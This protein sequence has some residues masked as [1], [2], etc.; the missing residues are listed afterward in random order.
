MFC[1]C[2]AKELNYELQ[3]EIHSLQHRVLE[4]KQRV[5]QLK[6]MIQEIKGKIEREERQSEYQD[7]ESITTQSTMSMSTHRHSIATTG[8]YVIAYVCLVIYGLETELKSLS[9]SYETQVHEL[10][11]KVDAIQKD[12]V[13]TK[14][15]LDS[16]YQQQR[17][18]HKVSSVESYVVLFSD[19]KYT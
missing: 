13:K 5:N 12:N 11:H 15:S 17:M 6:I 2:S 10:K 18:A 1:G 16:E 19:V 8:T 14:Q 4:Y 7:N 3:E 9:T